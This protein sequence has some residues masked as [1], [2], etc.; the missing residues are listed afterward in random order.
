MDSVLAQLGIGASGPGSEERLRGMADMIRGDQK[1]GQFYQASGNQD[2]RN[3]GRGLIDKADTTISNV[4]N[5]RQKGLTRT[6]QAMMDERDANQTAYNRNRDT[7]MDLLAADDTAYTR[8]RDTMTDE[9]D[10]AALE[11]ERSGWTDIE[12]RADSEGN[13]A[14]YGLK[15]GRG[16]LQKIPDSDGLKE[17]DPY[18]DRG[19]GT[20]KGMRV[21]LPGTD[22]VIWKNVD[23][24][25]VGPKGE[26]FADFDA[27]AAAYPKFASAEAAY[28][29]ALAKGSEA[30]A[31]SLQTGY[32]EEVTELRT[33]AAK[34]N[35]SYGASMQNMHGIL[36]A[37]EQGAQSGQILAMF[38][39]FRDATSL[40]ESLISAES[41]ALLNTYQLKPVS[42]AD[43]KILRTVAS[44]KMG[45]EALKAW[46][47]N[48][49]DVLKRAQ[50]SGQAFEDWV[51]ANE[52]VPRGDERAVVQEIMDAAANSAAAD[53]GQVDL[54]PDQTAVT[55]DNALKLT[56]PQ[57]PTPGVVNGITTL[58]DGSRWDANGNR[59]P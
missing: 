31:S 59:V 27:F 58:T 36:S 4:A 1:L 12:E 22:A 2:V 53:P 55:P 56:N 34:Q 11:Y 15:D 14:L 30:L 7:E 41:L 54:T 10:A 37:I 18:A 21:K 26:D 33:N 16:A 6:R 57:T 20:G 17:T 51:A 49:I 9:L 8:G 52:R 40:L 25:I 45:P 42:D 3:A 32:G 38:P 44:P 48:K 39:T 47:E 23:G 19:K 5:A 46:A 29:S 13:V 43:M 50:A 28:N 24:S 35:A